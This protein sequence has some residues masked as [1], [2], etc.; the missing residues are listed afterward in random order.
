MVKERSGKGGNRVY[1]KR[2]EEEKW[3]RGK[4]T[5]RDDDKTVVETGI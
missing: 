1:Y 5:G 2:N 4:V 3:R